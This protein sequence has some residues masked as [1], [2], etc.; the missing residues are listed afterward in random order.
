MLRFLIDFDIL[1]IM[2]NLVD[3]NLS[4]KILKLH[5]HE[6]FGRKTI[7]IFKYINPF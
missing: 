1:S 2:Y 5:L 4:P 3:T 7:N 6:T